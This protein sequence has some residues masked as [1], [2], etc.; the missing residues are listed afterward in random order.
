[1]ALA[2]LWL[3]LAQAGRLGLDWRRGG[4]GMSCLGSRSAWLDL[5]LAGNKFGLAWLGLAGDLDPVYVGTSEAEGYHYDSNSRAE[6][7]TMAM[8]LL[9][10]RS[11]TWYYFSITIYI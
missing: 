7:D 1:M 3:G 6:G 5:P 11:V 8:P 10:L 9:Y 4:V 2:W